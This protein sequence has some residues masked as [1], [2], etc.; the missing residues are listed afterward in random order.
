[1]NINEQSESIASL[2]PRGRAWDN[3]MI[4][5]SNLNRLCRAL[6]ETV[7]DFKNTVY[8]FYKEIYFSKH[9]AITHDLRLVEYGLP[10][11]CDPNS[12]TLGLIE[13]GFDVTQTRTQIIQQVLSFLGITANIIDE[14]VNS[15]PKNLSIIISSSSTIFGNCLQTIGGSECNIYTGDSSCANIMY[16]GASPY[17]FMPNLD[18]IFKQVIPLGWTVNFYLDNKDA[19]LFIGN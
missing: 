14:I 8:L 2:F 11:S 19:P 7:I 12:L 17:Q 6:S 3:V 16:A 15:L 9:T 5:G 10:N 4:A 1:M 18:C 13:N